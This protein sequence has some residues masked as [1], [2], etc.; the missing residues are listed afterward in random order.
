MMWHWSKSSLS[1]TSSKRYGEGLGGG[2]GGVDNI[3]ASGERGGE[4]PRSN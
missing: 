4:G 2:A 3:P 1:L